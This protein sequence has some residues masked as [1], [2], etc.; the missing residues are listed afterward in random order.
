[1]IDYGAV[2]AL[3]AG[4]PPVLAGILRHVSDAKPDAMMDLLRAASEASHQTTRPL[5]F[6]S[7][8]AGI[9]LIISVVSG[10]GQAAMEK[11]LS[12]GYG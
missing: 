4:I 3:P 10:I 7:V 8:A 1:M 12:R 5:L 11:R 6:Y 2:A 9:Y